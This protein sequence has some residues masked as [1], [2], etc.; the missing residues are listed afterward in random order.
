MSAACRRQHHPLQWKYKAENRALAHR[1]LNG[2]HGAMALCH[3]L[4]DRQAQSGAAGFPR[5]AAVHAVKTLGQAA[6]VLGGNARSGIGHGKNHTAISP[7]ADPD[8]DVAAGRGVAHGVADQ[9]AHGAEQLTGGARQKT[10]KATVK[11]KLM[12]S[13]TW[14]SHDL[15]E[16]LRVCFQLAHQVGY[17]HLGIH[18]RGRTALEFGQCQQVAHQGLHAVGLLRHQHQILLPLSILQPQ[19]L[20]GFHKPSQHGQGRANL[21]RH[22][23]HKIAAHG[24]SLLQHRDITRQQQFAAVTIGMKLHRQGNRPRRAAVAPRHGQAAAKVALR[25]IGGETGL[26]HQITDGLHQVTLQ[27]ETEMRR[28]GLIAPLDARLAVEQHDTIGRDLQGR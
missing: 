27:V 23:G 3:M 10:V 22:I 17:R 1:A 13:H 8:R 14:L 5:T 15:R 12:A 9:V 2:Q 11:D 16:C 18:P 6:Q 21:V 25:Q 24:L 4:D 7:L 19:R 26:T 20:Q 28:R